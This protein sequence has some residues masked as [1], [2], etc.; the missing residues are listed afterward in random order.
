[1]CLKLTFSRCSSPETKTYKI[2]Y[3]NTYY[4]IILNGIYCYKFG[5]IRFYKVVIRLVGD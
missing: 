4:M 1:M 5:F 2:V 3:V